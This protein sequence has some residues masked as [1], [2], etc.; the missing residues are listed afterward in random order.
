MCG[1]FTLNTTRRE[2][3]RQFEL[4]VELEIPSRYNIAPTD[5]SPIVRLPDMAASREAAFLRWGLVP[6]WADDPSIGNRMINA[7]SETVPD[8][9]AYREAFESRRCVVP[10]SGFYEWKK[11]DDGKQPHYIHPPDESLFGFAGLWERWNDDQTGEVI[12]SFTILTGEPN[13][14]VADVHDRMPVI[15]DPEDYAF[16]LDP[17][18]KDAEALHDL[19]RQTYPSDRLDAHPVSTH[20]NNPTNDDP[21]CIDPVETP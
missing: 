11:T 4:D 16:W 19:V 12:E 21:S 17:A 6:F 3:A 13:D 15:L 18:L 1:R 20:V 9:P 8:K 7:R 2:I 14:F 5:D 10:A